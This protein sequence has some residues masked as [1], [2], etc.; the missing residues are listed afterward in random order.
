VTGDVSDRIGFDFEQLKSIAKVQVRQQARLPVD[1]C[2]ANLSNSSPL[3]FTLLASTMMNAM[4]PLKE[5][6]QSDRARDNIC[7]H[8]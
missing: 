2:W 6:I 3:S 4:L 7:L 8:W 5:N 1:A